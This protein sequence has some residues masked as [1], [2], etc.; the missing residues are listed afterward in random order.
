VDWHRGDGLKLENY[1]QR[2][3]QTVSSPWSRELPV[4]SN[5]AQGAWWDRDDG[6]RSPCRSI[7][8]SGFS[9][10]GSQNCV[11][12]QWKNIPA[13]VTAVNPSQWAST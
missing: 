12:L 9:A 1:P 2:C 8:R 11:H 10:F 7:L 4:R 5:M 6:N 3:W 13:K